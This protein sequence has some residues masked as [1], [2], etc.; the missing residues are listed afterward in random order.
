MSNAESFC[1][2]S[3]PKTA[4]LALVASI[5][6][7]APP[8]E[9]SLRR[10]CRLQCGAAISACMTNTGQSARA[11]KKQVRLQCRQEGLQ[12]CAWEAITPEDTF[13]GLTAACRSQ[14]C[15]VK[16]TIQ[17]K[18][19]TGGTCTG[20]NGGKFQSCVSHNDK[21]ITS[22]CKS[23]LES[24]EAA[25]SCGKSGVTCQFTNPP[26]CTTVSSESACRQKGGTPLT[27]T[28]CSCCFSDCTTTSTSTTTTTSSSTTASTSTSTSSTSTSTSTSSTTTTTTTLAHVCMFR[29]V[30]SSTVHSVCLP[31]CDNTCESYC[32]QACQGPGVACVFESATCGDVCG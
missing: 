18:C 6:L 2:F 20:N 29:C 28:S 30:S 16:S 5:A 12:V 32:G 15:S 31:D 4:L 13:A 3:L 1:G 10:E 24:C 14:R 27:T 8:G 23:E 11:C 9:A 17:S 21:T 25:T 7:V 19:C 22:A 26:Q